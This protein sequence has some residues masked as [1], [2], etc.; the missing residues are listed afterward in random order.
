MLALCS[1]GEVEG[2][3]SGVSLVPRQIRSLPG[4]LGHHLPFLENG[5]EVLAYYTLPG[6]V[7]NT[8]AKYFKIVT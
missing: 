6:E 5:D 4:R 1:R 3:P 7:P 8:G 2:R